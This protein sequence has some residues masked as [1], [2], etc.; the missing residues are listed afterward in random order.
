MKPS[1]LIVPLLAIVI[2]LSGNVMGETSIPARLAAG[3]ATK[4]VC[5]GDSV[6][7]VYYHTGGRRAYT[8]VLGSTLA[9]AYPGTPIEAINAGVSGNTTKNALERIEK[10]V[11]VHKP[12]VVTVMF[13]L[14]DMTRVPIEEYRANLK[15]ILARV[16]ATGA[17][18]VLCT[19]NSVEDTADRPTS[20]LMAYADVVRAVA[21][22]EGVV[23]ADV[24]QDFAA[25]RA[26]DEQA[27]A[28]LMSDE[29]HP[30]MDG[31]EQIAS[32][33]AR[34]MVGRDFTVDVAAP[35]PAV[36]HTLE[37]IRAKQP[38][39]ILAMPP[40][41]TLLE[42]I[43]RDVAPDS[44]LKITP[45]E[46]AGK[47]LAEIEESARAIRDNPPDWVFIAVPHEAEAADFDAFKRHF[48][49]TM[50]YAL[51][52]KLQAWDVTAVPPGFLRAPS[53]KSEEERDGWART[54]IRAQD[55]DLISGGGG[56]E[57]AEA[58]LRAWLNGQLA[59]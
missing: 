28:L 42:R 18:V 29:I 38:I 17:E 40:Y 4:I 5:F 47:S 57:Q 45:W 7:G 39:E 21:A 33:I 56:P 52:F 10:D 41:D 27:W 43:L 25:I 44:P 20:K 48:T 13:G 8:D 11:L 46:V 16:R 14:N 51:S 3:H 30:N 55:F 1:N 59:G 9:D 35:Q 50:N 37:L 26:D 22:E 36:P 2:A 49:W 12:D 23:L 6:T 58:S 53:G 32:S 19:P 54:L 15:E 31:H 24:Y 34:A